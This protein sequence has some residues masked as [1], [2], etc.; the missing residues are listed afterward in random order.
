[1]K[2]IQLRSLTWWAG[3]LAIGTGAAR[4]VLPET[5][6]LGDVAQVIALMAGSGDSSPAALIFIGTGLIGIRAKLER[7]FTP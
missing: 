1:M 7:S 4:M 2:Y 3:A 6:P 5:G